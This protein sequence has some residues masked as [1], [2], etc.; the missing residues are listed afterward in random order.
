MFFSLYLLNKCINSYWPNTMT[1]FWIDWQRKCWTYCRWNFTLVE[2]AKVQNVG[3]K[4]QIYMEEIYHS[5]AFE[6]HVPTNIPAPKTTGLRGSNVWHK[7]GIIKDYSM[8]LTRN[9]ITLTHTNELLHNSTQTSDFH[10]LLER[11]KVK[12]KKISM[13]QKPVSVRISNVL[14]THRH[15]ISI[16]GE[17]KITWMITNKEI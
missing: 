15:I 11:K 14:R 17:S 13:L 7:S 8:D 5:C 6:K 4:T 3:Q 16:L 2:A 1:V 12:K 10:V 9:I